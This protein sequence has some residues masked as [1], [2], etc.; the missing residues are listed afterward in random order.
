MCV[1][2]AMAMLSPTLAADLPKSV[3]LNSDSTVTFTLRLTPEMLRAVNESDDDEEEDDDDDEN[4]KEPEEPDQPDDVYVVGN[5]IKNKSLLKKMGLPFGGDFSKGEMDEKNGVWTLRS[6]KLAP[7]MYT[8]QFEI[9]E[10]KYTD[11]L[12]PNT[13]RDIADTLSYF[14]IPGGN[15]DYFLDTDV[16]HGKVSKVWYPSTLEGF[17]QRRMSVYLP[18]EYDKNPDKR[19]PVLYLLHGSG[20]DEDAWLGC[21]RAAQILDNMMAQGKCKP[22]IVVMPNGNAELAAAPGAD[23]DRPDQKPFANNMSSMFGAI[24]SVFMHDV[25]DYVDSHYRTR[26]GKA[27]R[28]IAGLSLGGLHTLYISL[29]NPESFDYVGLFSAQTTNAITDKSSP[30]VDKI[31]GLWNTLSDTFPALRKKKIGKTMEAAAGQD[32]DIYKNFD[33]KLQKQFNP[34]PKLYYIAVGTGDFTKKLNDDLR[35]TLADH[36]Y[37]YVYHESDG[38]HTW[39]NWRNYLINFLPRLF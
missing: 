3:K 23:P 22:M 25:V 14:I 19:Y 6:P 29:N 12:N 26:T 1:C 17:K 36:R 34:A 4:N 2:I 11:P 32:A 9:D 37:P 21:G 20:G 31:G 18:A 30:T 13:V 8:Y 35:L 33:A 28:A 7:N 10:K 27:D 39:D 16:P 15:A 5:L 38:G 24:E